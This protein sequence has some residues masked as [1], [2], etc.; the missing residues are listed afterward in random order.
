MKI[1][2][3][4]SLCV[5]AA[6]LCACGGGDTVPIETRKV[7]TEEKTIVNDKYTI[8]QEE[9]KWYMEFPSEETGDPSESGSGQDADGECIAVDYPDFNTIY[10]MQEQIIT[11]NLSDSSIA[12]FRSFSKNGKLEIYNPYDLLYLITPDNTEPGSIIWWGTGYSFEFCGPEVTGFI[13]CCSKEAY[14]YEFEAMY[15]GFPAESTSVISDVIL[16][17][18]NAREVHYMTRSA[19]LK[20]VIYESHTEEYDFYATEEFV[21]NYFEGAVRLTDPSSTIPWEV[22]LYWNDGERY[23]Y[24]YFSSF[25]ERPTEEWIT[26]FRLVPIA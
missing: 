23:Y 24:G 17:D 2:C 19:E 21:L 13:M 6:L 22:R 16:T 5:V 11:G 1:R 15:A 3:F 4:V 18:R 9:E 25:T 10:E 8:Y 20:K 14:D 7:Y 12:L 26:G